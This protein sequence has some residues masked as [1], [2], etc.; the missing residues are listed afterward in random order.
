VEHWRE[1]GW[2][3]YEVSD[4]GRVRSRDRIVRGKLGSSRF[5]RGKILR[6]IIKPSGTAY[7]RIWRGNRYTLVRVDDLVSDAFGPGRAFARMIR[8]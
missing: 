3:G 2:R 8:P 1:T 6:P 7:V 5:V 4:R